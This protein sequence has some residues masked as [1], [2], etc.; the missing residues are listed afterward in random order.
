[1]LPPSSSLGASATPGLRL[2]PRP[3]SRVSQRFPG[4][5]TV[6]SWED[7]LCRS[8]WIHSRHSSDGDGKGVWSELLIMLC[9]SHLVKPFAEKSF[10]AA[11]SQPREG[12]PEA[13]NLFVGSQLEHAAYAPGSSTVG[14]CT[15]SLERE[16]QFPK[17]FGGI[18]K[19]SL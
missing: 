4:N 2:F 8:C 11:L 1:M 13:L 16:G 3:G 9:F 5:C 12:P 18:T 10:Y 7:Y 19:T 15:R 17:C 6:Q 14:C